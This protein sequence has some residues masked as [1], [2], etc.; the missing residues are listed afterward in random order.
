MTFMT[1]SDLSEQQLWLN[2]PIRNIVLYLNVC[3]L[4]DFSHM[5]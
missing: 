3:V 2:K 4:T 1:A 5:T